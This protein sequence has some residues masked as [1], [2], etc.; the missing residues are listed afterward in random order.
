MP[1]DLFICCS[2]FPFF[3]GI[4]GVEHK[5]ESFYRTFLFEFDQA[6]YRN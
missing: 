1:E 6:Y 5:K 2:T 4:I 3:Q